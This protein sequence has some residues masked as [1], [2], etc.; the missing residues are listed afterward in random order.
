MNGPCAKTRVL[1]TIIAPD[2]R[3]FDGENTCRNPQYVCP[4]SPG[5]GYEKCHSICDQVGHA[6]AV[7]ASLA[8]EAAR[9]GTAYLT[10]H[11]YACDPCKAALAA[12]GVTNIVIGAA[13][14]A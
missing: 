10:G 6:E 9:G 2:G 12:V 3:R 4:R 5:E 7:A 14:W 13:P 1:C 8:G 11:T